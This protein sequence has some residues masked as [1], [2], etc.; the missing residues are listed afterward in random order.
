[1]DNTIIQQGRFTSDGE[2]VTLSIRSDVDWMMVYNTTEAAAAQTT[3]LGVKYYWQRGFPAGA[4]W[5]TFKSNAANAANLEQYITSSGFTLVDDSDAPTYGT[6][7]ATITA[8][9]AAAIPVVTN[10]GTNGLVA[11][12]TVRLTNVTG[13]Q[14]LGGMTFTVGKNT[15]TTTTFSLDYMVQ[16]AAAT[17]GSWSKLKNRSSFVPQRRFITSITQASQAVITMSVDHGYSIGNTVRLIVPAVYGMTQ[18]NGLLG[19]VVD[20]TIS[21]AD[22]TITVDI[23]STAFTAFAF[24]TTGAVPFTFAEVVPVGENTAEALATGHDILS[25]ATDNL[26]EIG[27]LLVAGAN[28]PAGAANDVMY[29]VAG[30]SFSVSNS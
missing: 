30:K 18:M 11:G 13:A 25:D 14:H 5:T 9:S 12:D 28:C 26:G 22:N 6:L 3:A 16:I 10:S 4:K 2:N 20:S 21:A 27:M 17:T 19:T 24:P 8:I 1:M 15:L 23:D 29:W 7:N